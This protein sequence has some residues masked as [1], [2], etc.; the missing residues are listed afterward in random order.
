MSKNIKIKPIKMSTLAGETEEE[1]SIRY[2]VSIGNQVIGWLDTYEF[3]PDRGETYSF[4]AS[5]KYEFVIKDLE[6]STVEEIEQHVNLS[7]KEF[8][9]KLVI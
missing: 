6:S 5:G 3:S 8:I 2:K 7:L 1:D 4:G 9:S